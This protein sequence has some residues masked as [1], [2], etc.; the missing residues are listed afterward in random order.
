[1]KNFLFA[2]A[3]IAPAALAQETRGQRVEIFRHEVTGARSAPAMPADVLTVAPE[4]GVVTAEFGAARKGPT[5]CPPGGSF[6][7]GYFSF[8]QAKEK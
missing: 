6:S 4:A 1:M 8:G 3:L 2:L 7:F 5:D